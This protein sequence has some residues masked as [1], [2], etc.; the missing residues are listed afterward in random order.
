[1][2]GLSALAMMGDDYATSAVFIA[3]ITFGS[4]EPK[5]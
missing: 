1:M 5:S 4:S 3:S 2:C